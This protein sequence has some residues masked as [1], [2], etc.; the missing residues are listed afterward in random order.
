MPKEAAL[1]YIMSQYANRHP[2]AHQTMP[3]GVP[4]NIAAGLHDM[5]ANTDCL[6]LSHAGSNNPERMKESE[7]VK[8]PQSPRIRLQKC[9]DC[10][11]K[12]ADQKGLIVLLLSSQDKQIM[13]HSGG[14]LKL[15]PE[16]KWPRL[17]GRSI[18]FGCKM[19]AIGCITGSWPWK[20]GPV[21]SCGCCFARKAQL[22]GQSSRSSN[23]PPACYNWLHQVCSRRRRA[24]L[25]H[26]VLSLLCAIPTSPISLA[27]APGSVGS[28]IATQLDPFSNFPPFLLSPAHAT[29][30]SQP[31]CVPCFEGPPSVGLVLSQQ[32]TQVTA[33]HSR[34]SSLGMGLRW[35]TT[36]RV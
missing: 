2:T 21:Q 29:T 5:P 10:M 4:S 25:N 18:A 31:C 35:S 15:R 33:G 36:A 17:V 7:T 28:L 22:S 14:D 26:Q 1:I 16:A 13:S 19:G 3:L 34:P 27:H 30:N 6:L 11:E 12:Q 20:S 9:Q 8:S 32:G 23:T 24:Q